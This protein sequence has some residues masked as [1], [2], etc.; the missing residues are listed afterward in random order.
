MPGPGAPRFELV[1]LADLKIDEERT[2]KRVPLYARLKDALVND[3][4]RFRVQREGLPIDWHRALFLNLSFWSPG[5]NADVVVDGRLPADVVAHVA[6]HH[7]ARRS[8][9]KSGATVDGMLLGESIAS[10]FDAYLIGRLL[11]DAPKSEFIET[12]VEAMSEVAGLP[13]K[14]FAKVLE[15][16]AL[17]PVRSFGQLRTLLFEL[18]T[19]LVRATGLDDAAGRLAAHAEHPLFPLV[20]HYNLSNWILH[21]RVYGPRIKARIDPG[22]A[23]VHRELAAADSA[24]DWLA[25]QWLGAV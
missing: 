3:G 22:V 11:T 25:R 21:G 13:E 18:S 23:G 16:L 2:M 12:Q 8:L 5:D 4:Y 17:D 6:W 1:G 20:H 14:Q 24:L 9:G 10:A 7:L 15:G 19:S